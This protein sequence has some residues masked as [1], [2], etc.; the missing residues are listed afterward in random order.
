MFSAT[1]VPN[2]IP[3]KKLSGLRKDVLSSK[4]VETH[5]G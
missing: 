5:Y 3:Q 1:P 4:R 2:T